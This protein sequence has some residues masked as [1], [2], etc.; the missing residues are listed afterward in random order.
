MWHRFLAEDHVTLLEGATQLHSA[1]HYLFD[2][3]V[4]RQN[5]VPHIDLEP[6]GKQEQIFLPEER[7]LSALCS[8]P[9]S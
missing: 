9:L 8:E 5:Q 6:C 2:F 3:R 1:E 7:F 4:R